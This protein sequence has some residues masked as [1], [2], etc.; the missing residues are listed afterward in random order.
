MDRNLAIR[1]GVIVAVLGVCAY[2]LLPTGAFYKR[3]GKL[4][5]QQV[6]KLPDAERVRYT[7]LSSKALKLGLDL[8]GGMHVVMEIDESKGKVDKKSDA[9][10]RVMQ[11]LTT[12]I[13]QFGVTEPTIAKQGEGRILLQLPGVDDPQRARDLIQRTAVLEFR[14]VKGQEDLVKTIEKVDA[15]LRDKAKADSV[16]QSAASPPTTPASP[17]LAAADSAGKASRDSLFPELATPKME[18]PAAVSTEHPLF[19]LLGQQLYAG[20]VYV[21]DD[22]R[23][24]QRL[25]E[26][27]ATPEAN[28]AMPADAEFLWSSEPGPPTSDGLP[29]RLVYLVE[30]KPEL[31]G[32][33]LEDA[34]VE[35]DPDR[36]GGVQI[37]FRLDRR[38]ARTFARVTEAN[39]GHQLAIV[40]D[41]MVKSAPNIKS[42]IPSGEGVIQG[43][44]TDAEARDLAIV[45][46]AG[47]LPVT[48]K[49]VEERTVGPTLG[50]D[51]LRR[52]LTAGLIGLG[53]SILFVI[54]YYRLSG[55]LTALA[56]ALNMFIILAAMAALGAALSLPGIAGLVL[57]VAMAVDANVLIFERI[58]E[59]LRKNKTVTASI[60]AGYKNAFSAI[61]D[62]NLTT[63][64]AGIVLL[65]FGTGPVK[66]FAVTLCI[67]IVASL[68]T[69]LYVTRFVYDFITRRRKL[70][71]LSI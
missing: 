17:T 50:A 71:T 12:R 51:S 59:E 5:T 57:S 22:G 20:A 16:A 54:I 46:R 49:F 24:V 11:V 33:H 47:A 4:A 13:D 18:A 67:G 53:L 70:S 66:G 35:P 6:S 1:L 64:F 42:K 27:L 36:P 28:R 63:L 34:H 14:L 26:L 58:R 40:L 7:Q 2:L 48:L 10:D 29:T 19:S 32:S 8:R 25:R 37:N 3:F 31:L 15:A 65:Y 56:L 60:E 52:G 38:G 62:S 44:Y 23:R 21:P 39:V 55:L 30:K 9:L 45:L 61:L 41:N 69:A 43:S 68:F